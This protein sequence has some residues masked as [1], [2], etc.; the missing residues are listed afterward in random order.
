MSGT[1][2]ILEAGPLHSL[3]NNFPFPLP[4]GELGQRGKTVQTL[5]CGRQDSARQNADQTMLQLCARPESRSLVEGIGY[6]N[7]GFGEWAQEENSYW[8]Q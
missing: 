3:N 4:R 8:L 2:P 6:W 1:L 7:V 5:V